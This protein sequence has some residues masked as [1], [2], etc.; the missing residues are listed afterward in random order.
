[1]KGCN[2]AGMS[3]T[4]QRVDNDFYATPF[5][6]TKAILDNVELKGSI[7]EPAAGQGHISYILK[8]YYPKN[9]IISTDLIKRENR[10]NVEIESEIDFLTYDFVENLIMLLQILPLNMQK[11]S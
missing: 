8:E 11:S 3:T 4:R 2:L 7:L 9:E 1:M 10:F 6:A 5:N